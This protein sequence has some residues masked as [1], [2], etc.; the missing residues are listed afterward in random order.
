[1][2]NF[3]FVPLLSPSINLLS[4]PEENYLRINSEE[5]FSPVQSY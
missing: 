3:E 1:M 2:I 5:K 4:L